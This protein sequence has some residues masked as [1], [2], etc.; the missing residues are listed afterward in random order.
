MDAEEILKGIY[1]NDE[2]YKN[3]PH[4]IRKARALEYVLDNTRILCDSRDIFPA[5]NCVDTPM[6]KTLVCD[7][8]DEVFDKV[9]PGS[10]EEWHFHSNR[11]IAKGSLDFG[12]SVPVW[13]YLFE[14]G[15][16]GVLKN[17]NDAKAKHESERVLNDDEKAFF[18]SIQIVYEAIIRFVGRLAALA[19]KSEGCAD[20]AKALRSLEKGKPTTFYEALMFEYLY[21]MISEHVDLISARSCGNFDFVERHK[22]YPPFLLETKHEE[23]YS[24]KFEKILN[25]WEQQAFGYQT[26]CLSILY[27]IIFNMQ[28]DTKKDY[29]SSTQKQMVE[30]AIRHIKANIKDEELTVAH[31]AKEIGITP[32]YLRKLFKS[33]KNISP[34]EYIQIKRMELAKTF[35]ESGEIKLCHIPYE[36]GFTDYT[37]FSKSFKK[38]FGITPTIYLKQLQGERK[39]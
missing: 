6:Y 15:F 10:R 2:Q 38:H 31:I 5:I 35:L 37:Y 29:V 7:W 4:S 36:C 23:K 24:P 3:C 32:E 34:K 13:D 22:T 18:E 33:F 12:H 28:Q 27:D 25:V 21:F 39:E 1:T 30:D 16:P 17:A 14:N 26:C 20:M 19:E 9:V 8:E 11:G